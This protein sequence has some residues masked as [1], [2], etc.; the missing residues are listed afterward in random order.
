MSNLKANGVYIVT[1]EILM[2]GVDYHAEKNLG[3]N[4][5]IANEVS[6]ERALHQAVHRVGRGMEPCRR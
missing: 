5:L 4:L 1:E 2:R 3:I 6:N